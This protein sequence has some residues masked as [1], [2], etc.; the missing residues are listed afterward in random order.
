ML[1]AIAQLVMVMASSLMGLV[2]GVETGGT[3]GLYQA[4]PEFDFMTLGLGLA[5]ISFGMSAVMMIGAP[6]FGA[7]GEKAKRTWIPNVIQ[8]LVLLGVSG[9]IIG[10]LGAN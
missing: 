6:L 4:A 10:L 3:G 8:G 7:E 2:A 1:V 9:F 5:A